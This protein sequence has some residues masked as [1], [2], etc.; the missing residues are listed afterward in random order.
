M[1]IGLEGII[2][3]LHLRYKFDMFEPHL[4]AASLSLQS[5]ETISYF[6]I[7]TVTL[8]LQRAEVRE[9]TFFL[10]IVRYWVPSLRHF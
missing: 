2:C 8:V 1:Y 3:H 4:P 7:A 9:F 6:L 10:L 5:E